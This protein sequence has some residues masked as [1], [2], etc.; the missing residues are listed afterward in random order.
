M[1]SIVIPTY[2]NHPWLARCVESL[3]DYTRA[4]DWR[5]I[6]VDQGSTD[7]TRDY[8]DTLGDA[9]FEIHHL[10]ENRGFIGGTNFGLAQVKK[11]E[12]VLLLNDDVQ[13]VDPFWLLR[14]E[15]DLFPTSS[16][17]PDGGWVVEDKVGA[18]GPVS[19]FVFGWQGVDRSVSIPKTKHSARCLI[20]FCLLVR[21]DA[22]EKI[23]FLDS[24]FADLQNEDF[25]Y[26]IRLRQA[27]YQLLIDR[28]VFVLHYGSK[29]TLREAKSQELYNAKVQRGHALL[30]AKW[31]QEIVDEIHVIPEDLQEWFSQTQVQ[32]SPEPTAA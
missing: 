24:R 1:I 4:V 31:G 3:R 26:S 12:H 22:F 9:R 18:V 25:D 7:G 19:N 29:T 6:V 16:P 5:A 8:L 2:N 32:P 13:A 23:G 28:E 20:G 14:M 15:N 10:G 27:G 21:A 17:H 11:G 30:V